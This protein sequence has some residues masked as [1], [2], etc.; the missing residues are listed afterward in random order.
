VRA[1]TWQNPLRIEEAEVPQLRQISPE[2]NRSGLDIGQKFQPNK[3]SL[4]DKGFNKKR[5]LGDLKLQN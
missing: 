2:A 3:V 1:N 4:L 5:G